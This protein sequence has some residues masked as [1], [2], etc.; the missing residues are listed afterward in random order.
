[1]I[2]FEDIPFDYKLCLK[3]DCPLAEE[4]LRHLAVKALPESKNSV[5]VILPGKCTAD[6]NGAYPYY[7]SHVKVRY[8]RGFSRVLATFPVNV[9]EAFR[10]RLISIYP[11]NKYFKMRRGGLL[12]TP[13][14][15]EL[16]VRTAQAKG[17]QGKFT[18]DNYEE[19]YRWE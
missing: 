1:M 18:F 8:A 2:R 16:I 6:E 9:L 12:L 5:S 7:R 17:F 14:E 19:H 15:Q 10:D 11:R 13:Q 4:C 3:D